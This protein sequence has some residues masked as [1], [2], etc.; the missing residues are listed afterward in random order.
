MKERAKRKIRLSSVLALVMTVAILISALSGCSNTKAADNT[1]PAESVK[2]A[3]S[4]KAP[5]SPKVP[6]NSKVF[7]NSGMNITL[8]NEFEEFEYE[9]YTVCYASEEVAVFALK[10]AFADYEGLK[11]YTLE[12]YGEV[13][14]E[15]NKAHSPLEVRDIDGI[16]NITYTFNNPDTGDTYKYFTVL[17]KVSDAFWMVQFATFEEEYPK[18]EEQFIDWAKMIS[19]SE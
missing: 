10:E 2:P 8:T 16:K 6:D 13:I 9:G 12:E 4:T 11:D 14:L 18:H 17:Y 3:E 19:F 15:V 7:S 1:K 5:E